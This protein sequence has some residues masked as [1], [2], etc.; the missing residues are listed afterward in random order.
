MK[1]VQNY[2]SIIRT[3]SVKEGNL[4]IENN[5]SNPRDA[6][7]AASHFFRH[8][9]KEKL[10][11]VSLDARNHPLAIE[12]VAV[13]TLNQ[14]LVG[15]PEVFRHAVVSC[16]TSIICLH[17]H[18]SGDTTPSAEDITVTKKL[19]EAG[20][21]LGIKLLDHIIVGENGNYTSIKELGLLDM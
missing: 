15:V 4:P 13:G 1:E 8:D 9:M 21:I 3:E 18:P 6:A 19:N 2:I 7:A 16:A 17:N 14:C 11:V 12:Q 20:K 10:V 5:L